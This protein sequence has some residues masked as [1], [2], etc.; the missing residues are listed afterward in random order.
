MNYGQQ[1]GHVSNRFP[2]TQDALCQIWVNQCVQ[3]I[4]S[5]REW[6]WQEVISSFAL[7]AGQESYP[8][9]G[10]GTLAVPDFQAVI[11]VRL[12]LTTGGA[13]GD[14]TKFKEDDYDRMTAHARGGPNG[15]PVLYCIGG[16]A[17]PTTSATIRQG[18]EALNVFPKPL[19][20]AGNGQTIVMR[21][22]RETI[23]MVATTD[24]PLIPDDYHQVILAGAIAIGKAENQHSDAAFWQQRYEKGLAR[25]V[26]IDDA[27]R[28]R[29]KNM[30]QQE[31]ERAEDTRPVR[32][33]NDVYTAPV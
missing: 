12:E 8:L 20:T 27:S 9:R 28:R 10:T 17:P 29:E 4:S 15:I 23:E 30:M 32:S 22:R 2:G 7:V 19:A 11:D 3:D 1:W 33:S 6:Y 13:G 31:P 26:K 16:Q 18:E 25:M 5:E 24:V 14:L 21:Y